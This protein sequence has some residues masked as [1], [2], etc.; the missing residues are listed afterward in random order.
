MDSVR[1][2]KLSLI[3]ISAL[4]F[5]LTALPA[6]AGEYYSLNEFYSLFPAEKRKSNSFD[7]LVK[8]N[9]IVALKNK[10]KV[11][12]AIV[13]PGDQVSDYWR[14]SYKSFAKRLDQYGI[15]PD[16][17]SIF[18]KPTAP[19]SEQ[20]SA[21]RKALATN[22][23]YLVFTLDALRHQ[24]IIESILIRNK[25]S[26]ILQNI[27]TPLKV[28]DGKQPLMYIGFDHATGTAMLAGYFI[29]ATGGKGKYAVLL[30]DPG[31]LSQERGK[32]FISYLDRHS[33][34]EMVSVF[35]TGINKEKARKATLELVR[36]HPDIKFIYACTTDIALGTIEGLRETGMLNKIM[37]NGWGGGSPE[38]AAIRK[39]EM[40]VT[41]MRIN[42]DNGIAMAD[43]IILDML[44]QKKKLPLVF[45]GRFELVEK[46][47]DPVRLERLQNES[48]RYSG[49]S[50]DR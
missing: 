4:L 31:Y 49:I 14:R 11:K 32:T 17:F 9:S 41:V 34:L 20:N 42:D 35:Q 50:E 5:N 45:S 40:T 2:F 47:I 24:R 22:P 25:P 6:A 43:A 36:K 21:F 7:R 28:W 13:Y 16:L 29:K 33:S 23:D 46:G 39:G 44:G 26:I 3:I 8:R 12:I 48:F 18:I 30:P 1:P 37:V 19:L 27:T 15:K 10:L 38:L